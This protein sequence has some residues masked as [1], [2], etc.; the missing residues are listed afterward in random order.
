MIKYY[1]D[2]IKVNGILK[3]YNDDNIEENTYENKKIKRSIKYDKDNNIIETNEYNETNIQRDGSGN[4]I[5][6]IT[7]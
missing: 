7:A 2:S 6:T 4:I 3:T 5:S 1:S